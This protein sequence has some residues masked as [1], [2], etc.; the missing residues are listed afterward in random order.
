M[1]KL[2]RINEGSILIL[3]T[4]PG[5]LLRLDGRGMAIRILTRR[6]LRFLLVLQVFDLSERKKGKKNLV[7]GDS[8]LLR[9]DDERALAGRHEL[10]DCTLCEL[11]AYLG[12]VELERGV[13]ERDLDQRGQ[14]PGIAAGNVGGT[15][16]TGVSAL[17]TDV[18]CVVRVV[19]ST[20]FSKETFVGPDGEGVCGTALVLQVEAEEAET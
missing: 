18:H 2:I 11:A 8:C 14:C 12:E 7:G 13:G 3:K 4:F 1:G 20:E 15:G 9:G 17:V 16:N 5:L 6:N 10:A 19:R